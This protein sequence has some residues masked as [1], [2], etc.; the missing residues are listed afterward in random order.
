MRNGL[1]I[2][3]T[4]SARLTAAKRQC[5]KHLRRGAAKPAKTAATDQ[6]PGQM[7]IWDCI[8]ETGQDNTTERAETDE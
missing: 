8:A 4:P 3:T 1:R 7:D 2:D 6:V 5:R